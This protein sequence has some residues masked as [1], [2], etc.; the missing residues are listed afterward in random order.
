MNV[1]SLVQNKYALGFFALGAIAL[2]I[3]NSGKRTSSSVIVGGMAQ[4]DPT[5]VSMGIN[6]QLKLQELNSSREV[7]L[8]TLANT[9]S[10]NDSDNN[11]GLQML[12]ITL[13]SQ[14]QL[15]ELDNSLQLGKLGYQSKMMQDNNALT[16]YMADKEYDFKTTQLNADNA[17]KTKELSLTTALKEQEL[18]T[19]YE[20]TKSRDSS[21]FSLE[22]LKATLSNALGIETL[23][24]NTE[25]ARIESDASI[26]V[27]DIQGNAAVKS[28]K[29]SKSRGVSCCGFGLSF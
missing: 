5:L 3:Y 7:A 29:A 15:A 20:L 18:N 21:Y 24:A 14:K 12:G 16:K 19:N 27:A 4:P 26:R 8:A 1:A 11:T 17:Y 10:I 13:G 9:K 2:V 25:L 22:N 23:K 6:A 28:A